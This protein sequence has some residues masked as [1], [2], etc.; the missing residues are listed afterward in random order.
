MKT[1]TTYLALAAA[2][3]LAVSSCSRKPVALQ[4]GDAV[5]AEFILPSS[6]GVSGS[7]AGVSTKA[8][9]DLDPDWNTLPNTNISLLPQGSTLWL[10]YARQNADGTTYGTPQ[11]QGYVVG[12]A[13]GGYNTL[14]PCTSTTDA[15]GKMH[16]NADQIGSPLY[17][18]NGTYKFKMISPAYPIGSDL[19]MMVDNGMYFYST[20]GRY[21]ETAAVPIDIQVNAQGVQ[22]IKLNP[23]ISQVA[24]FTFEISKGT[25][26]YSIEPLATGIEIS[27]L[28]NT[29][30]GVSYNWCSEH[31]SDTLKMKYGDKRALVVLAGDEINVD[32][33]G[34]L[35]G[36]IAVLP[37]FCLSNSVC[38]LVN[39]AVNGVAT[40]FMSLL[41]NMTLRHAHS[42]NVKWTVNMEDGRIN[43]MTWQNQSWTADLTPQ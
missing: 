28:Q 8:G 21:K 35:T 43:V 38:I 42:Y 25:G 41:E 39:V 19:G 26:V 24:R 6:Y 20:D 33:A 27:G 13:S 30:S 34:T 31:I 4:C 23:I 11:L 1:L 36:D 29:E 9:D 14:Y 15:D 32:D 18:E 22:Y 12:S 5:R 16:I 17:L 3:L 2:F 7:A 10:T 40:Q 37:T